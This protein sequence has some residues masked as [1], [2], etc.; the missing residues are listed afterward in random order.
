MQ[1]ENDN[2]EINISKWIIKKNIII[3][4]IIKN[5]IIIKI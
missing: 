2:K 5:F 3:K 1:Q 4:Q